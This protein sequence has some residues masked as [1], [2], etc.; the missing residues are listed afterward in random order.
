MVN[1]MNGRDRQNNKVL[2]LIIC[3]AIKESDADDADDADE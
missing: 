2:G 1:F 3:C